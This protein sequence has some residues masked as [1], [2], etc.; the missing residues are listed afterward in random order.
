M[1][2]RSSTKNSSV[3]KG[4]T[5]NGKPQRRA[6]ERA[7][8]RRDKNINKLV[9]QTSIRSALRNTLKTDRVNKDGNS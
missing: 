1:V 8:L 4:T 5:E 6:L 2:D 7:E 3:K 9:C